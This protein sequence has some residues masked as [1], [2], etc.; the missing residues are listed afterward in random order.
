MTRV[1]QRITNLAESETLAMSSKCRELEMQG[2]DVINLSL[3][4]PDFDTPEFIK[5]AA[6]KAMDD[7]FTHYTP[8]PAALDVREAI[9]LKFK[10]D[11]GLD[12]KASEIVVSTGA[13]QSIMNVVL[14]LVDPGDEVLLPAPYWVSYKAMVEFAEGIPVIISASIENEYKITAEQLRPHISER[15]RMFLFSSPCNPSG[16]VYSREELASLADVFA[17]YPE[18]IIVSDEIY[19]HI[20]F[21][22]KHESI[23]QFAQIRDRVVTVNGVSKG[24]AMTGW[25]VGYIGAPKWIAD[26]CTKI[27]GQFTSA[28]CSIAQMAAKAAVSADPSVTEEMRKAFGKRRQLV[29]DLMKDIP[30]IKMNNPQG[31]FY[32]FP[33]VSSYFG[34]RFGNQQI[35]DAGDLAMFL[36]NEAHVAVVT[37]EAFGCPACVRISYATSEARLTEAIE[38]IRKALKKLEA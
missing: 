12:F 38:R 16:S 25:R 21:I 22:G 9:A 26:A 20:N 11:N 17:D 3:G 35:K 4:E 37:G 29:L 19:E 5:E 27:Q 1:S 34:K 31:A 14:S 23:G 33:D 7:N 13:K 18:L 30:G 32:F 10:R 8:V 24:F 2:M 36:L 6:R 15:T 28:T